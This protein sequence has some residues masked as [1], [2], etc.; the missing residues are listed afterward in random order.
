MKVLIKIFLAFILP[1]FF[2]FFISFLIQLFPS[3]DRCEKGGD[4]FYVYSSD[5]HTEIIFDIKQDKKLFLKN[6]PNL[7]KGQTEGY[8]AF[9]YGD[10]DFMMKIP[11]WDHIK[12]PIAL[13][14]L[15]TNTQA[16]MRVGHYYRIYLNKVTKVEISHECKKRL[17]KNIFAEFILKNNRFVHFR[18]N[19]GDN[20]TFYFLAKKPYN[21]LR[22]CNSWSGD[23]LRESGFSMGYWTPL[24]VQVGYHLKG[25]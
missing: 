6:F 24:A 21:L 22:T 11:D 15:F 9:S 23:I 18:D 8:L 13:K 10:K 19:L 25:K 3:S 4:Y 14:A 17:L 7:L 1:I 2:Y 12:V 5:I 16:L 20:N